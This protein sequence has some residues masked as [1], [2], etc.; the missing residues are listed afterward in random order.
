L[1]KRWLQTP[2]LKLSIELAYVVLLYVVIIPRML[3]D[4]L[5]KAA[6]V[7]RAVERITH[8]VA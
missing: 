6:V 7:E 5:L 2:R 8:Y 4:T 3:G 1:K